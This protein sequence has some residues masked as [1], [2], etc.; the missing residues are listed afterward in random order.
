MYE[1]IERLFADKYGSIVTSRKDIGD[2][3]LNSVPVNVKSSNVNKNNYSPN[4]ISAKKALDYLNVPENELKFLFVSYEE[5]TNGFNILKERMVSVFEIDWNCLSI[6]CQ[7]NGVIQLSKQLKTCGENRKGWLEKLI[8]NY[9]KYL[10]KE[11]KKLD[12]LEKYIKMNKHLTI[13]QTCG[14]IYT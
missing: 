1:E 9:L 5:T 10:E 8:E 7:G 12:R 6:Q 3:Y 14:K 2:F 4:L 11:R 13:P